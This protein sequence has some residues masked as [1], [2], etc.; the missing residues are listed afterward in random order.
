M[1]YPYD[2]CCSARWCWSQR[3]FFPLCDFTAGLGLGLVGSCLYQMIISYSVI[4]ILSSCEERC[5]VP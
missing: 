3:N 2:V 1:N 4:E 5:A